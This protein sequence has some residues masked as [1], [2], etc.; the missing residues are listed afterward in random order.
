MK[1]KEPIQLTI[2]H[3]LVRQSVEGTTFEERINATKALWEWIN[4]E[5]PDKSKEVKDV[6][7]A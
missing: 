6:K 3:E 5:K 4:V 1:Q 7:A 2:I